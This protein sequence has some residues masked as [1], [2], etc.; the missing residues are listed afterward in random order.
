MILYNAC[1]NEFI[2]VNDQMYIEDD[3][4]YKIINEYQNKLLLYAYANGI[5]VKHC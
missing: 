4:I 5:K 2:V 1:T 3:A